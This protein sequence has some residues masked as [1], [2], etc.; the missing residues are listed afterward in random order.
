MR[1]PVDS[2]PGVNDVACVD[3]APDVVRVL[4]LGPLAVEHDGRPLHVAGTHR[5]RLLA[6]LASRVGQV[7]S[8]DAIVD[9]LW[10]DDPPATAAR[11]IQ[12]HIARLRGSFAGVDG[13]LIET[14]AGG[15]R[16]ALAPAA[17]DATEFELLA[18]QGR[19][20]LGAG[21]FAG[22]TSVLDRA[23]ALWRGQPYVDFAR[24]CRVRFRRGGATERCAVG[25]RRGLRRGAVGVWRARAGDRRPGAAGRRAVWSGAGV[26]SADAG[27]V[28][29]RPATRCAGGVPAGASGARRRVRSRSRARSCGRWS[30]ASWSRTRP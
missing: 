29:G 8:V 25:G 23:L 7:V 12:S 6:F 3:G 21:D 27:V 17:V 28:R 4:V 14:T 22:A 9:A 16:L 30:A 18:G 11:T 24:C 15:Y 1:Q 19:R 13:E 26:G 20:R 10:G 5:R 2:P